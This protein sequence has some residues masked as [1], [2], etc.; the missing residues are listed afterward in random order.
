MVAKRSQ[1]LG[2]GGHRVIREITADHLGQPPPLLRNRRLLLA[3]LPAHSYLI[4]MPIDG[5]G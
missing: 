5:E 1:P 2:I 3:G 4:F